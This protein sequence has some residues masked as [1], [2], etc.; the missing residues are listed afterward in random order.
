MTRTYSRKCPQCSLV[1]QW[2]T[3]DTYPFCS[4]RCRLIDLGLW[5]QG[6]Y[7]I[8]TEEPIDEETWQE[9]FKEEEEGM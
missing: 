9:L 6:D 4:D 3:T 7:R 5:A 8:P 2:P 1:V